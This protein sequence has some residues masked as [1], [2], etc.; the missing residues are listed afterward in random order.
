MLK[1]HYHRL[2]ILGKLTYGEAIM[3][4][5]KD[6]FKPRTEFFNRVCATIFWVVLLAMAIMGIIK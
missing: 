1:G 4:Q 6:S 2:H 3:A 5:I